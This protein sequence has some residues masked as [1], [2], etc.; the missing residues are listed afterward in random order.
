[1]ATQ[2]RVRLPLAVTGSDLEAGDRL[3][4]ITTGWTQM[5]RARVQHY[6]ADMRD[7]PRRMSLLGIHLHG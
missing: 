5:I 4:N 7:D 2:P 1:M 6:R 3:Q